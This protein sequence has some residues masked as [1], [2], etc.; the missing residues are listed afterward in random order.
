MERSTAFTIG[1]TH[2][3]CQNF[4]KIDYSN[5]VTFPV[6]DMSK[7]FGAGDDDQLSYRCRGPTRKVPL[8]TAA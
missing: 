4:K 6:T 2:K 3:I 8:A 1:T 5:G 7:V